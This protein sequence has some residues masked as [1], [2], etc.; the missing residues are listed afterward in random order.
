MAA[1]QRNLAEGGGK[2]KSKTI[3]S[4]S[5]STKELQATQGRANKATAPSVQRRC[6]GPVGWSGSALLDGAGAGRTVCIID[7]LDYL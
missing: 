3:P 7:G 4:R 1:R 2:N 5:K 6:S